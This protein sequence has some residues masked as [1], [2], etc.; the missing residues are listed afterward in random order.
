MRDIVAVLLVLFAFTTTSAHAA[1]L[2][3]WVDKDGNVSY[4]D[5]PP[6]PNAGRVEE[7]HLATRSPEIKDGVAEKFPVV[8]YSI[9]RCQSC[10]LA[11]AYLEKRK[12]PFVEKNVQGNAALQAEMKQ[13][14]GEL[15]AP[16]ILVGDKVIKNYV[17]SWLESELD[18]AGYPKIDPASASTVAPEAGTR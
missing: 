8:L 11:R 1:K 9:P 5:H 15:M 10:D 4:Q 14:I 7:K 3:K 17:E 13:K 2:Y 16:A 18:Q 12:V 6:P